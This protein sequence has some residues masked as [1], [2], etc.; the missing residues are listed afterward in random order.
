MGS[1]T[2]VAVQLVKQ[3][4]SA[5]S[6]SSGLRCFQTVY[7]SCF[8]S[9]SRGDLL[10]DIVS[11]SDGFLL[12]SEEKSLDVM[13]R[14]VAKKWRRIRL[15][16]SALG[17]WITHSVCWP[18]RFSAICI[19]SLRINACTPSTTTIFSSGRRPYSSSLRL[20]LLLSILLCFYKNS[21]RSHL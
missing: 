12:Q 8:I 6:K 16:E 14:P 9:G 17:S 5:P 1:A 2:G 11:H 7:W 18:C 20:R 15:R 10:H 3:A 21:F 19:L 13:E 4:W